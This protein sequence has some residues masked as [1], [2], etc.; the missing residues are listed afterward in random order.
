MTGTETT[1]AP[2]TGKAKVRA[3]LIAPLEAAGLQRPKGKGHDV[4]T[5]DAML[6]RLQD[7]LAYLDPAL[8]AVLVDVVIGLADGPARNIWPAF[9]TILNNAHRLQRPPDTD[10]PIVTSWLVSVEGPR[11]EAGGYLVELHSFLRKHGRP[12]SAFDMAEIRERAA[13][14]VR[15]R[16]RVAEWIDAGLTAGRAEDVDWLRAYDER[17]AYC[18]DLVRQGVAKRAAMQRGEMA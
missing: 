3:L 14:N 15:R 1:D 5:H 6:D 12:P 9:A 10:L 13:E 16:V 4:A 11:A 17:L 8:L 7:R 18:R 2:L